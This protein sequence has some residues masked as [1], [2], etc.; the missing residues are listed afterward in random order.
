[1]MSGEVGWPL[2]GRRVGLSSFRVA[3]DELQ[4]S[5]ANK[6]PLVSVIEEYQSGSWALKSPRSRSS[7]WLR[8][9]VMDGL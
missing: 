6:L 8:Y 3:R 1:M 7:S 9:G 2:G 4:I 5:S